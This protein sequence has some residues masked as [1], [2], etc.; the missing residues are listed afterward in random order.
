MHAP[1]E[2]IASQFPASLA[3]A[4][5][6]S[7][8]RLFVVA[9]LLSIVPL[10]VGQH[11]PMV[12]IAQHAAQISAMHEMWAGSTIFT[13]LFQFNAFTPYLLGYLLLYFISL[14]VPVSIA[15][16]IVVSI[17]VISVPWLTGSLL[18][19]VGGDERWKWLAIPCSFGF[20]FYWGLLPFIMATPIALLFIIYAIRF[21]RA[22]TLSSA[23]LVAVFSLFLFFCH[24]IALC[25]AS[26]AALAYVVGIHRR[27]LRQLVLRVLPFTAPLPLLALWLAA[28]YTSEPSAKDPLSFGGG[29]LD[30]LYL[31]LL[32]SS[33]LD[34][35]S[36]FFTVPAMVALVLLPVLC[37]STFSR[38][39]ER[40]LPF[41]AAFVVFMVMPGYMLNASYLYHRLGIFLTPLWLMAWD[42]PRQPVQIRPGQL[43]QL[44]ALP[45][46]F[47][48]IGINVA[49][50]TAFARET[51]SFDVVIASAE[52][53]RRVASL[54][55]EPASPL[56]GP[57]MYLRYASW[58]ASTY[59][60]I[61]DFNSADLYWHPVRYR[62]G[63]GA[64]M[65]D[66]V[67]WEP[68]SFSW[69]DHG[70]A[71]YDY[72]IVRV[73]GNDMSA[74]IFKEKRAAVQLVAHA[75]DWWLYRNTE[76]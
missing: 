45:L 29:P 4:L 5:A 53:N 63:A 66:S 57:P 22:P 41:V 50:F 43:I 36:P 71:L 69:Q 34:V 20:A 52:P 35:F 40:W 12:D 59:R 25:Y 32:Q 3:S 62:P 31:L 76:R 38:R 55:Y 18:R 14:V 11:L 15:I 1:T 13:D 64:R 17:A 47:I 27:N 24:A 44:F 23:P 61:V 72:F 21:A 73:S 46:V 75:D 28:V 8:N 9:L 68:A 16:Q 70:G 2:R 48:F 30:R 58:Y 54:V 6:L 10:W 51:R 56:F 26:L 7:S 33:G 19:A 42:A 60:G 49:R 37:G 65:T 39:T 74:V 67:A